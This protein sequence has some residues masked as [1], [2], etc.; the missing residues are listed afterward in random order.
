[1]WIGGKLA[2]YQAGTS[3]QVTGKQIG[4]KFKFFAVP[5]AKGP[6]GKAGSDY[7]VDAYAVVATSKYKD[8]AW[9]LV[10]WLTDQ[11]SGIRLGEIGGTIGGR[12]DVYYS[13][14]I[15]QDPI[16]EVFAKV[17][18]NA[19]AT[20]PVANTRMEEYEKTMQQN[21]DPVWL[22]KEKPTKE[23]IDKVNDALQKVLDK[24]LP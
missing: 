3:V 21:L 2:M 6:T 23:Y 5:N 9:E 1:M 8:Q 7:E 10:K 15:M 19:M 14:R 18:E 16:R 22:G 13:P 20:R 11:E 12:K 17:M 24:P 4:D